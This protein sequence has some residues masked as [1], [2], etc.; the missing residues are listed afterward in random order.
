MSIL[1]NIIRSEKTTGILLVTATACSLLLANTALETHYTAFWKH[2]VYGHSLTAWINDALMAIFFL[3]IGLEL[4]SEILEGELSSVKKAALPIVA[5]LGGM[6]LP[7]AIFLLLNFNTESRSGAGIPMATDIAFAVGILSLLGKRI[8]PVLKIFLMALAVIDDLGAIVVIAMFYTKTL[9]L[10]H[11]AIAIAVFLF[12]L[13]LNAFRVRSIL[14][15]LIGGM[16]IWYF[17]WH[18]GIHATIAGVLTAF[19]IPKK[20]LHTLEHQLKSPVTFFIL[21]LFA[22]AN[23]GIILD[24]GWKDGL[25]SMTGLGI[26]FGLCI[27]KPAGIWLFSF[28]GV[29]T[30]ICSLPSKLK[31]KQ[32]LGI[33]FLGGIGFTMSIFITLLAF[34]NESLIASAKI[35]ILTASLF[36]AIIGFAWL[37]FTLKDKKQHL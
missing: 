14:I 33:G 12:L 10:P 28:I 11:L 37:K 30:R 5:A 19:A 36:S 7:A 17:I 8:S 2:E 16:A 3:Y 15:Y 22:L 23:T 29:K 1:K 21:P 35:A 25:V 9:S 32:L 26:I 6:M 31:W 13:V 4:K 20:A 34:E 18:S 24:A 27:G